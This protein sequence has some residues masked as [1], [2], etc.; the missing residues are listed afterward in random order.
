MFMYDEVHRTC[1]RIT[2]NT[3]YVLRVRVGDDDKS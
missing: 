1:R 2:R 3:M